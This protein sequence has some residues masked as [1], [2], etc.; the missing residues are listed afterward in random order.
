MPRGPIRKAVIPAAGLGTRFLPATKAV[1]KEMLPIVDVPTIQLVVEEALGAGVDDI[2]IVNGRLKTAIEDHFDHAYEL[3]HTLRERGK[4][5]LLEQSLS[6]STMARLISVR[7]KQPLGLGHAVLCARPVVGDEPFAVLLGDDLI[8]SDEAPGIGQL[9]D[10]YART[11]AG[12]VAV[13]EV[14][15]GEEKLY[16]IIDAEPMEGG[17]LRVRDMV[18][19]PDPSVAPSRMAVIGRYVLPPAIW[20]LLEGLTPGVGGEIQLTDALQKLA[21]QEN[22]PGLVA[23]QIR[24]TRHDAGH[25]LGYLR[26]NLVYAMKRPEMRD[27]V[28][29]MLR[30]LLARAEE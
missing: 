24:G 23:M 2:V 19:K 8:D 27:D 7:Q 16:G 22:G 26:A 3:E 29:A 12:V 20:P 15:P 18:E 21:R 30:E 6:V 4:L 11:G 14:A 5:D 17:L 28:L 25:K 1:P 10:V 13:M 9:C